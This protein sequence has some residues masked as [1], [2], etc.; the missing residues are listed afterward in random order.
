MLFDD[1]VSN[2]IEILGKKNII[3]TFILLFHLS[4]FI[5]YSS[6]QPQNIAQSD[7]TQIKADTLNIR[8][9]QP[10]SDL[11]GPVKYSADKISF[12]LE[13]R[14]TFLEGDVRIKYLNM[15][16]Q[17]GKVIIDWD[18][19]T[20]KATG[21]IDSTDSLGNPIY[22]GL[23]VFSEKGNEPIY[24]VELEYNFKTQRGKILS[25]KTE[26]NPGYYKGEDIKKIGTKTLLVQNGYF[27]SCD[28][29]DNPHYYFKSSQMRI[30]VKKRAVAKPIIMYIEDVPVFAVPFGVFPMER[31]RRSGLIIPTFGNSSFGGNNLRH[32]GFYWAA[33]DYWDATILSNFYEK[34]GTAYEGEVRYK[35]RYAFSGNVNGRFAPKDV[36]TG[37]KRQRWSLNFRHNQTINE[38]TTLN[39]SGSF[40][41]DQTFL[42]QFSHNQQDRLNQVLQ[43]NATLSKR[44]PSSKNAV[45][46][47]ISRTENLQ[48][49]N[50]DY[51][52]PKISFSHTQ[53][54]IFSYDPKGSGKRKWYH[55]IYYNYNSN[56]TA[57]GSRTLQET[58]SSS[59]YLKQS[60]TGWQHNASL[61][62]NSKIFKY[63]KYNQSIRFNELWVPKY[64]EYTFID[65]L[66]T[67][68]AD[69]IKKFRSRHT[70]STSVGA[71]T[72]IYG[73]FE[74]PFLPIKVIRHKMDPSISF[75]FSPNFTDPGFGYVQTFTDTSGRTVKKDRFTGNP[76]G[77]TS[78]SESRRMNISINNLFQGKTIKN[79]E[80]KKI[81]LFNL[82]LNSAYNFIA[83][84]LKWSDIRS[85]FR[86][87]ASKDF[88]FTFSAT[89]SL[90][91]P[92]SS[93]TSRRNEYVWENGFNF[94][95][96]VNFQLNARLHIA[97]PAEKEK[98]EAVVDTTAL[99]EGFEEPD[100]VKDPIKEGLKNFKLPWDITT[101][102][103]Y[104][105]N[106]SNVNNVIKRF[107]ANVAARIEL[108]RNWRIQYSANFDL[109]NKKIN[110]QS[111]NIYRDLHCWEMSFAWGPN[112][113]G[114]SFFT[115]EIRV[116]ESV[117]RDIKVTKSSSGRRV[118]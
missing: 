7:T 88:D 11:E 10:K 6:S 78:S 109:M 87:K 80:E 57:N 24:G 62:F 2:G 34:T 48:N 20:M 72:T 86:A 8:T 75:S 55:D 65:S 68:V 71:S 93:G 99:E 92:R 114:Y 76:F 38:T 66:N 26:M 101:N 117:L 69:T 59:S 13:G 116:K 90:Y 25:G 54:N 37:E 51:T 18:V 102:F 12:S 46:A 5:N 79:G 70:F 63:L 14:K 107:D 32:L 50:L 3:Q 35:K 44:W 77:G 67:A 47:N 16:L 21:I 30:L 45:T 98:K 33:S 94:P 43:T 1:E 27:T 108:T 97:P 74:V 52:L 53:S 39:A 100:I 104:S 83:D 28:S 111:F 41:S 31:G 40:V 64:L 60:R 29:I 36:N 19:N 89:H 49:G 9:S 42:Q 105:V 4:L 81:D 96:L 61:S 56:F 110:Y 112:P 91:K 95:R 82:N 15:D 22:K 113:L 73:L 115:F 23:P 85:S 106:K 58:D 118:Y 103:T 17:A 84:S